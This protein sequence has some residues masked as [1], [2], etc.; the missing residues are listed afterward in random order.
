MGWRSAPTHFASSKTQM[1]VVSSMD[2]GQTWTAEFSI[3]VEKDM[4]EPYFLA[5]NDT[6]F[7]Y[8]FEAGTNPIAFEPSRLQ[9]KQYLGPQEWSEPEAWG[10]LSE[11]AWQYALEDGMAYTISYSGEHYSITDL[12]QVS[13][14]LNRSKNGID[15]FP[16]GKSPFYVGG[17]SEVGW[18][19]DDDGLIWGVG[20]NEDGDKSGW[21]SRI[22]VY[23]RDT[24]EAPQWTQEASDPNIYE[25][26]RMFKHEGELYL[27]ARTDP[28]GP[29]MSSG[30]SWPALTHHLY[31]LVSYSF[32]RH[33]TAMWRLNRQTA[34]LEWVMDLPGCGDNAFP[35]IVPLGNHSY[36]IL[37]Y[38]NPFD[39]CPEWSWIYGQVAPE[40]A[41]IYAVTVQFFS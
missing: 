41:L 6:L 31:D 20:R 29:F 28:E 15:W 22:F 12:G 2:L 36:L 33:G 24:M 25:S 4:R 3:A 11:V 10:Q 18:A 27:V 38:S 1:H 34:Q 37:N 7:F 30:T 8:Y 35:S 26:P 32:R 23:D 16:V 19:F 17:I 39:L 13:L 14:Y 5:V 40:G 9:R 21:G